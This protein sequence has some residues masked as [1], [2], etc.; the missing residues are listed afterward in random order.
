MGSKLAGASPYG[1]LDMAGN[2]W[3]WVTDWYS[4]EYYSRSPA[5]NPAGP[6]SGQERGLRG[7]S[8]IYF[9]Y[10]V[11]AANRDWGDPGVRSD[12]IGFRCAASRSSL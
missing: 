2:A 7:G 10:G 6:D 9:L 1:A 11:R 8:W 3:E 4:E 5:R 12:Y